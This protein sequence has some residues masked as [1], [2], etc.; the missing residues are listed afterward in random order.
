MERFA[1]NTDCV[2]TFNLTENGYEE[3]V[4]TSWKLYDEAGNE[5]TSS[6]ANKTPD[7]EEENASESSPDA[8]TRT[9]QSE[10]LPT[11]PEEENVENFVVKIDKSFNT[12]GENEQLGYRRLVLNIETKTGTAIQFIEYLLVGLVELTPMV[13]SYQTYGEAQLTAAKISGLQDWQEVPTE[14]KVSALITAFNKIGKLNFVIPSDD[15]CG[16][17]IP[18]L[19]KLSIEEFKALNPAFVEAI[20]RAQVVEANSVSGYN[21]AEEMKRGNILSY[22]IGET[23][24][25]FKTGNTYVSTLSSDAMDILDGYIVRKIRIA[26]A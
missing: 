26:R 14:D 2:L 11:Y 3:V 4:S 8:H 10:E 25:M 9:N 17:E 5:L 7:I 6:E 21:A 18:N 12:L 15:G 13:N 22:T 1:A 24:Q 23:S 19:N 16:M 20:K